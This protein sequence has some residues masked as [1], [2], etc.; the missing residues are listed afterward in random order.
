VEKPITLSPEEE[1]QREFERKAK[2]RETQKEE[3]K[4]TIDFKK[5]WMKPKE[6]LEVEDLQVTKIPAMALYILKQYYDVL[7]KWH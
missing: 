4:L 5:L 2:E 7:S 3:K 1:K 6:D